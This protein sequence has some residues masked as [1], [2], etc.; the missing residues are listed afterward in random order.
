MFATFCRHWSRRHGFI[1]SVHHHSLQWLNLWFRIMW[2][3]LG[4][5]GTNAFCASQSLLAGTGLGKWKCFNLQI[6][7]SQTKKIWDDLSDFDS[8][9]SSPWQ[10]TVLPLPNE[11]YTILLIL[12]TGRYD[13]SLWTK[14]TNAKENA[15]SKPSADDD[16]YR[17]ALTMITSNKTAVKMILQ[18]VKI[19]CVWEVVSSQSTD[20][21]MLR[22]Y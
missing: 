7:C 3:F 8:A 13:T 9:P 20:T 15:F 17:N 18:E 10:F 5:V 4:E 21:E 16:A 2:L 14:Q 11:L 6:T 19:C 12:F 1:C 22:P